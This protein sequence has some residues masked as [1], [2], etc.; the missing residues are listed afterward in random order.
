MRAPWHER[1]V[2]AGRV[3]LPL[4]AFLSVVYLYGGISK[5][6]DRRFLDGSSPVS[7]HASVVAARPGSPVGGL[8][9]VV[10]S[11]SFAFGLVIAVAELAVGLGLLAGLFTRL[12]AAGG[13]LIALSLWL[14]V[15]WG[16]TPWFTSADL[17]YLFALTPLLLAGAGGLLSLDGWLAGARAQHP[18][19]AE[20]HTRRALI[21]GGVA[22][23][24][25]AI[26]AG[27]SLGR[28]SPGGAPGGSI[29]PSGGPSAL[30][31]TSDVPVGGGV[32]VIAQGEPV[33]VLQLQ[34][35]DF[36]ALDGR[37]PHQGCTVG[38]I[39]ASVG[40]ACPCHGSRFDA[41]GKLLDG[42][43]PHGLT[44]IPVRVQDGTVRT[45]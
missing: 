31:S 22:V 34:S 15:S 17:V 19:R 9:G 29:L 14:T 8:L 42:P 3:L 28:R 38:F 1:P 2:S 25:G 5:V 44:P 7:M 11:H 4:R 21:G 33:W 12:A 10:Q 6:A 35:G 39:S 40:F 16:A 36:T 23:V 45:V 27:A 24:G 20:D 32:E 41:Q 13:M 26:L 43:A 18:G 37:C 30:T